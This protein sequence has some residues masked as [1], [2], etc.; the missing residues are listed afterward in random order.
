[1]KSDVGYY[2]LLDYIYS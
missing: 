1:M 2:W